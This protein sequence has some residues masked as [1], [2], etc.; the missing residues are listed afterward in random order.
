MPSMAAHRTGDPGAAVRKRRPASLVL[1]LLLMLP[2]LGMSRPV[3]AL[4]GETLT[5]EDLVGLITTHDVRSIDELLPLL[6]ADYRAEYTLMHTSLSLQPATFEF[7]RVIM[8]GPRATLVIAFNGDPQAVRYNVLEII[9]FREAGAPAAPPNPATPPRGFEFR[10]IVFSDLHPPAPP[11]YRPANQ[12]LCRSCHG[13]PEPRPNWEIY[14][15][16]PGAYGSSVDQV[17]NV[18]GDITRFFNNA[19]PPCPTP[20]VECAGYSPAPF[21]LR[22]MA[23]RP[24]LV[25]VCGDCSGCMFECRPTCATSECLPGRTDVQ[26]ALAA[27]RDGLLQF[28][29]GYQTHPRYR[30]LEQVE[31]HYAVVG[32]HY[33]GRNNAVLSTRFSKLNF[34]RLAERYRGGSP[35]SQTYTR[36]KHLV[37]LL[38]TRCLQ[39]WGS[40]SIQR[41]HYLPPG[42]SHL[43]P[44]GF[45]MDTKCPALEPSTYGKCNYDRIFAALGFDT[46][47]W[48]T[49][50]FPDLN[51]SLA[52]TALG[53]R[54]EAAW[55][56]WIR[57]RD[58]GGLGPY[59]ND[60]SPATCTTPQQ[61]HQAEGQTACT[62][63]IPLAAGKADLNACLTLAGVAKQQLGAWANPPATAACCV[64]DCDC[65]GTVT[66][67]ELV[68]GAGIAL[69]GSSVNGCLAMDYDVSDVL[70]VNELIQG[71]ANLL[72]G[73]PGAGAASAASSTSMPMELALGNGAGCRGR[74]DV[75]VAV[76]LTE[77]LGLAAGGQ[78]DVLY[79]PAALTFSHCSNTGLAGMQ[80][81]EVLTALPSAPPAPAGTMRLRVMIKPTNDG[82]IATFE[83]GLLAWCYFDV[84][85]DAP[86][87]DSPLLTEQAFGSDVDGT[88]MPTT[89]TGG[90]IAITSSCGGSG[91]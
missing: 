84:R 29:A 79:D 51:R 7:P 76:A 27:E 67:P 30:W 11:Q 25:E 45:R 20:N 68:A 6:P 5:Y 50:F 39:D 23:Y 65:D 74:Q 49:S 3:A 70:T 42:F 53:T 89:A 28:V 81:H 47:H 62:A 57:A 88:A 31:E 87:G 21:Q 4:D 56:Y 60:T 14:G 24:Y 66:V 61:D 73:C 17:P 63:E 48:P 36:T 38:L 64:G 22:P 90:K 26:P 18:A 58:V 83:N 80:D 55:L 33:D 75:P 8:T 43:V 69:T 37:T 2:W 82:P 44:H 13:D 40:S 54:P 46:L 86:V 77:G 12:Q 85:S 15:E 91:C 71:V 19:P 72:Y 34:Q 78:M 16:W 52:V 41:S 9:Q 10:E 32:N 59:V 35:V 1:V